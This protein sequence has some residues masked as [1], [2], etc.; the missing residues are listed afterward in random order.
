MDDDDGAAAGQRASGVL[1]YVRAFVWTLESLLISV[2][3]A[4]TLF[5]ASES[6]GR[7]T[8]TILAA[9]NMA[10]VMLSLAALF[11]KKWVARAELTD[12]ARQ[13][14]IEAALH[15]LDHYYSILVS[16]ALILLTLWAYGEVHFNG[17]GD[18]RSSA[19]G[20]WL[21]SL[22]ASVTLFNGTGFARATCDSWVGALLINAYVYFSR[23]VRYG[24]LLMLVTE[25]MSIVEKKH[26]ASQ[27]AALAAAARQKRPH[28]IP[29]ISTVAVGLFSVVTVVVAVF[30][31]S[32]AAKVIS[33]IVASVM[34]VYTGYAF[35]S[36][37]AEKWRG[38]G[39][40]R[41]GLAEFLR[42]VDLYTAFVLCWAAVLIVPWVWDGT[43]DKRKFY[44]IEHSEGTENAVAAWQLFVG[45]AVQMF[46]TVGESPYVYSI[47]A[48]GDAIILALNVS[49]GTLEIVL[50]PMIISEAVDALQHWTRRV[51]RRR[52]AAPEAARLP[53]ELDAAIGGDEW[54]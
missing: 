8:A 43:A 40:I 20:A 1:S 28:V 38:H 21:G 50:L 35:L 19:F 11:Y 18:H 36:V 5:F 37:L 39:R 51:K 26:K 46:N 2:A 4:L 24:V 44:V 3:I 7:I 14:P 45:V 48:A 31:T 27:D 33:V 41:S 22:S 10:A 9:F 16:Y 17:T 34:V 54:L 29:A 15:A 6:A 30:D 13:T 32:L 49:A 47:S 23:V 52:K 53:R 42:Y 12:A 25:G